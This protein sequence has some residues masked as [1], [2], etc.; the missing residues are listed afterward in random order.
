MAAAFYRTQGARRN[1]SDSK[2]STEITQANKTIQYQTNHWRNDVRIYIHQITTGKY[3]VPARR[4]RRRLP[5]RITNFAECSRSVKMK[6]NKT[7]KYILW[8]REKIEITTI[9]LPRFASQAQ[10][11][12][13]LASCITVKLD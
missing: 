9:L 1:A 10:K 7:M 5:S 8:G 4:R 11:K 13:G 2:R 12:N 3:V 6:L